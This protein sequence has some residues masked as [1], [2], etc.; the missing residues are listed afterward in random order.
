ML[1]EIKLVTKRQI[2]YCNLTDQRYLEFVKPMETES[3]RVVARCRER[4]EGGELFNGYKVFSSARKTVL[5]SGWTRVNVLHT[6]KLCTQN[7]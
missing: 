1:S 3:S 7:G 6:R 5:Q 2:V 4:E